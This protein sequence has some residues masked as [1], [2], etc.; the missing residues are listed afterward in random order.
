[1]T[2]WLA[3]LV[4]LG[5]GAPLAGL[6]PLDLYAL[7]GLAGFAGWLSG[8]V[9]VYRAEGLGKALRRR[10]FAIY[11]LGPPGLLYLLRSLAP[12]E[13]Q[14]AAPLAGLFASVVFAIFMLVP[15]TLKG[16]AR[17]SR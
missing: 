7:Y 13:G 5:T 15:V 12:A 2:G 14:A 3:A 1:M 6:V 10:L 4:F 17:P 9:Y 16:S 11:L 8:N